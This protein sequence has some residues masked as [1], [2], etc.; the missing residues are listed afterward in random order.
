[1][2]S[3]MEGVLL[4]T[5]NGMLALGEPKNTDR[6]ADHVS[7]VAMSCAEAGKER[8]CSPARMIRF[9]SEGVPRVLRRGRTLV[10]EGDWPRGR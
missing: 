2:E 6:L 9:V 3:E 7:K 10:V 1:M 8:P 4:T 5:L